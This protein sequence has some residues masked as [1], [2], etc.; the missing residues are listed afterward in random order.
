M[1]TRF[2]TTP[3]LSMLLHVPEATLYRW[4]SYR[5]G[6]QAI[7]VGKRLLYPESA[8]QAWLKALEEKDGAP[9]VDV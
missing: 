6:P 4:R 7:K 8:I 5:Q 9:K 2:Y 3:E 1:E